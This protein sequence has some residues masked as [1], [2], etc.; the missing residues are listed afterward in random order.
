MKKQSFRIFAEISVS[1]ILLLTIG[2]FAVRYYLCEKEYEEYRSGIFSRSYESL[3]SVL[4]EYYRTKDSSLSA[5]TAL[6]FSNLPLTVEEESTAATFCSDIYASATDNQAAERAGSYCSEL[7]RFLSQS[8]S[9]SYQSG[10]KASGL[11]IPLYPE[12]NGEALPTVVMP[13]EPDDNGKAGFKKAA[14]ALLGE[15]KSRLS[16]YSY[17]TEKG[18]VFGF[19]TAQSY[20]EYSPES[21]KL[22]K[23]LINRRT[24]V[25]RTAKKSDILSA[26]EAFLSKNGYPDM[27][28]T[29]S[30]YENGAEILYFGNE[31]LSIT[32][33]ITSDQ[34]QLCLFI[35]SEK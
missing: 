12:T 1:G 11:G 18:I 10:W 26:A 24:D 34:C 35:A 13:T 2:V 20:A 23:A 8:R 17:K 19:R 16:E 22:I 31:L 32:I 27:V 15:K 25:S 6:C 4:T 5:Q 33:G 14:A 21:G 29:D 3:V 9:S 28:L 30:E 7:L